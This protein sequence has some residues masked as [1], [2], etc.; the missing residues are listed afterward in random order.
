M[1]GDFAG[2]VIDVRPRG[3]RMINYT[4]RVSL[5]MRDIVSRVPTLSFIDLSRVLVFAR[6]GR[7]GADG[8]YATC[9]CVCLPASDPGYY[10]W[11]D[12][13]TGRLTRRS[14]WFVTKSPTIHMH[15]RPIDYMVSFALPRFCDQQL[16]RSR[17]QVHYRGQP[18]WIAKLDTIIHELY[19]ID[20]EHPGIRRMERADGT[21]SA[22][23]HGR[24]FFQDVVTMV[25]QYLDTR[26]DPAVYEFLQCDFDELSARFGTVAGTTFLGF[27]SYPQ[28]YTE[29]LDPQPEAPREAICP[30]DPLKLPRV[31]KHYSEADLTIRE[32]LSETS[33]QLRSGES[34]IQDLSF[35]PRFG[36]VSVALVLT[37][38]E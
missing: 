9:H 1:L 12:R 3:H 25:N 6:G 21:Y 38:E 35:T 24:R 5:L 20:P 18:N 33:R 37:G 17:K 7:S 14:E 28:R 26:P 32:F 34:T 36:I 23:C 4:E 30:V 16:A 10:F 22:N 11:R 31:V 15:G 29:V 27:P 19:H 2:D 8:A 13:S